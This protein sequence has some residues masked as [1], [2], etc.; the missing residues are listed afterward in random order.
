MFGKLKR[1][2]ELSLDLRFLILNLLLL[3]KMLLFDDL[4]ESFLLCVDLY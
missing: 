1:V 3:L 2:L 4:L